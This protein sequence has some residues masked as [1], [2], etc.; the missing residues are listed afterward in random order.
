MS[1]NEETHLVGIIAFFKEHP[2]LIV[3]LSMILCTGVGYWSEYEL[4]QAFGINIVAFAEA[5]DF[6][7]AAF[8]NPIIFLIIFP[9]FTV[10][11]AIT[12]FHT[13]NLYRINTEMQ[14]MEVETRATFE[15]HS[16]PSSE[17]D[18]I[19]EDKKRKFKV[20]HRYNQ[21]RFQ[22]GFFFLMLVLA[23]ITSLFSAAHFETKSLI[24]KIKNKPEYYT[25]VELRTNRSLLPIGCKDLALITA[26]ERYVFFYHR[27]SNEKGETYIVPSASISSIAQIPV[28]QA[29]QQ[30]FQQCKRGAKV[31]DTTD[32]TFTHSTV[33]NL[34]FRD[35]PGREFPIQY[36][37]NE[38]T[39]IIILY[40]K[41]IWS[42][43]VD[44]NT[45]K[46]GWVHSR[47][48]RPSA[49]RSNH[50]SA[51]NHLLVRS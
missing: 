44:I 37:L 9:V 11:I 26:T 31:V 41:D 43:V 46:Q 49:D 10:G 47:Y 29:N 36:V 6:L 38:N 4:M 3:S 21:E 7:L 51:P 45:Q 1:N 14:I 8:K 22:L 34:N 33:A 32:T 13:R 20:E 42:R 17:V 48:L 15:Q 50:H 28:N 16:Y 19:V 2:V 23:L 5:D 40:S 27:T 12:L 25:S 30:A 18:R 35:G 24:E 39:D